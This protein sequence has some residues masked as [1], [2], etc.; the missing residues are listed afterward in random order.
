MY[1]IAGLLELVKGLKFKNKKAASFGCY[2]WRDVSTKVIENTLK[3]AG[4]EII[5]EPI[6]SPW[7][8]DEGLLNK[9]VEFGKQFV[10]KLN[11][12]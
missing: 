8:P 12:D 1:S 5:S 11:K 6:N 3:E 4:F 7:K 10:D 9:S 2:G